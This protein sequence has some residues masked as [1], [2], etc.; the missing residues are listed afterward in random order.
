LEPQQGS[1]LVGYSVSGTS[2][3]KVYGDKSC[4]VEVVSE[5]LSEQVVLV[6]D[7][8]SAHKVGQVTSSIPLFGTAINDLTIKKLMQ[9]KRPVKLWLDNDQYGLLSKK[10]GRLQSFLG[11]PVQYIRT[12]KDPKGYTTQEIKEILY[13]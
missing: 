11:V 10:I 6:E 5:Q 3:W 8:I 1:P 2:K 9:L 12:N 7:I 4:Y 13:D